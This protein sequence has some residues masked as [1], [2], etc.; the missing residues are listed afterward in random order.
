[1]HEK[2]PSKRLVVKMATIVAFIQ[3][4]LVAFKREK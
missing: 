1:M 4:T 2:R 3:A